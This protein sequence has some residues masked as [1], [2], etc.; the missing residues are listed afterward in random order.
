MN[1]FPQL[2]FVFGIVHFTILILYKCI[3]Y[4]NQKEPALVWA[5]YITARYNYGKKIY[6]KILL[7]I[8]NIKVI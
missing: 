7:K 3:T 6:Q 5:C 8:F 4:L 1:A 2:D